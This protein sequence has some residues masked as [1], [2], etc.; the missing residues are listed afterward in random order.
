[1]KIIYTK[2]RG[3]A[4]ADNLPE[5]MKKETQEDDNILPKEFLV[6]F[7]ISLLSFPLCI[8]IQHIINS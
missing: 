3:N 6:L 5:Q 2:N 8:L 4:P 7:I 1:M